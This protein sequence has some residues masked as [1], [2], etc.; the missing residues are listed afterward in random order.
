MIELG[1]TRD[2]I[3]RERFVLDVKLAI[4]VGFG[5][6]LRQCYEGSV[7]PRFKVSHDRAPRDRKEIR[8]EMLKEPFF[9]IWGALWTIAQESMWDAIGDEIFRQI[10][11]LNRRAHVDKPS[12]SL[13]VPQ[14]APIPR[15]VAAIHIHGQPGG[16]GLD[17]SDDDVTAG[18]FCEGAHRLYGRGQG[19]KKRGFQV[20]DCL[21]EDLRK[22]YP[23]L[24]PL[25]ILDIGCNIGRTTVAIKQ[26][27]PGAEVYGIDVGPGIIRYAH[28][29]AE[30]E[31]QELHFAVQNGEKTDFA[32]EFFDLIVSGTLL[33]ETS[34][35]AIYNIFAEC[36]RILSLGGVMA[37][38]EVALRTRDM[39]DDIYFQWYRDWSTHYNAEPFWGKFH[40]MDI[41]DP[42][43]KGGFE[44][45]ESW[46]RYIQVP[47]GERW[48]ACGARK[49]QLSEPLK[50]ERNGRGSTE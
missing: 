46:E 48:W 14:N 9:Q 26:A 39:K 25:R 15:Y 45:S 7:L 3:A 2:E 34:F 23:T 37:H 18:V 41:I 38:L 42:I 43:T 24:K 50:L 11:S 20:M 21:V 13:K 28:A 44:P 5:P 19:V 4:N 22:V 47:G 6:Q 35:K 8:R 36:N 29:K 27:F 40:D 30:S 1:R 16:Y 12:G 49:T 32:D 33:H 31:G 10:P 17:F